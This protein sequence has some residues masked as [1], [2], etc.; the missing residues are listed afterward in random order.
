M[1]IL[2]ILENDPHGIIITVV[3]V[4][5]V[6]A[7]LIILYFAYTVTGKLVNWKTDKPAKK[8]SRRKPADNR[9][10]DNESYV[11]TI[12]REYTPVAHHSSSQGNAQDKGPGSHTG[13]TH[14]KSITA[15]LPGTMTAVLVKPGDNIKEGQTVAIL[16]AMKMENDIQAESEGTV[17]E[18]NVSKGD[19]VLEGTIIVTLR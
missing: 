6:F 1:N 16:E 12:K 8:R 18:V 17:K 2:S 3:S 19:S 13:G 14:E 5:V 11:I 10:H 7:A 15:P 9:I 4:S